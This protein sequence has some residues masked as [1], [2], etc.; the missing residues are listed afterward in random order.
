[1]AQSTKDVKY[2]ELSVEPRKKSTAE[3]KLLL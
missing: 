1:M 2:W 3:H